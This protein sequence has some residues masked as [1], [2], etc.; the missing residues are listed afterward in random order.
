MRRAPLLALASVAALL[1]GTA[2]L[3]GGSNEP[4]QSPTP[5][6]TVALSETPE[7]TPSPTPTVR[8]TS[9]APPRPTVDATS[10]LEPAPTASTTPTSSPT[11]ADM[12]EPTPTPEPLGGLVRESDGIAR[13]LWQPG[14]AIDWEHGIF[15]LET[16]SGQ[17]EG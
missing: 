8:P 14:E 16:A 11:P 10:T 13:R 12:P 1:L 5:T 17:V 7:A 4:D 2:C 15:F 9:T 6:A 3:G